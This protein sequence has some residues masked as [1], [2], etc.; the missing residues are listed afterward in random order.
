V[1]AIALSSFCLFF[2]GFSQLLARFG[3][4]AVRAL[5]VLDYSRFMP[6]RTAWVYD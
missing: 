2:Q 4:L 5:Q 6:I 3:H 1:N